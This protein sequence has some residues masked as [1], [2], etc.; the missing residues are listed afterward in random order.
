MFKPLATKLKLKK[1]PNPEIELQKRNKL[2]LIPTNWEEEEQPRSRRWTFN[3]DHLNILFFF[4][5]FSYLFSY[6]TALDAMVENAINV[7][8]QRR[9]LEVESDYWDWK[10]EHHLSFFLFIISSIPIFTAHYFPLLSL[11]LCPLLG[12]VCHKIKCSLWHFPLMVTPFSG[13]F[14]LNNFFRY[15][16]FV[17]Y[18]IFYK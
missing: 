14:V 9:T 2:Y 11:N 7:L 1:K 3:E 5:F 16:I 6:C 10:N 4:F 15:M 13:L 8:V 12:Q 18:T 17:V